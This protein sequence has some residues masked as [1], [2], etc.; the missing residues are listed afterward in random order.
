MLQKNVIENQ[1]SVENRFNDMVQE[2]WGLWNNEFPH[3]P[4]EVL[5]VKY[6]SASTAHMTHGQPPSLSRTVGL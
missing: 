6:P 2:N 3:I 4:P 1:K 5:M